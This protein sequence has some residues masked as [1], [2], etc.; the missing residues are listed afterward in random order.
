[1]AF[2]RRSLSTRPRSVRRKTAWSVGPET[3]T[4]GSPQTIT[5]AGG[6][7]ANT[8]TSPLVSG[9]TM[10]R[11]RGEMTLHLVTGSAVGAGFHGAFGIAVATLA[12]VTAGVASV[13]TPLTEEDWDGWLY[14]RYFSIMAPGPIAT[15]NV[16]TEVTGIAGVSAALRFEIDS[17]AMRKIEDP[18]WAVYA[19]IDTVKIGTADMRWSFNSR[20]LVK[21]A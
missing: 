18:S 6:L 1:M 17:K 9:L 8:A 2:S 4:S 12:A 20:I 10:V 16:S 7:L 14:H 21:L 15:A 13:P 3:G 19:A 11:T 5:A